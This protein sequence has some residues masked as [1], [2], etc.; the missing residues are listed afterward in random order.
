MYLTLLSLLLK[1]DETGLNSVRDLP[2][3]KHLP[4]V[5]LA[6]P[7]T[8]TLQTVVLHQLTFLFFFL[9]VYL[10]V[11]YPQHTHSHTMFTLKDIFYDK[12]LMVTFDR[13]FLTVC[14]V[15][16]IYLSISEVFI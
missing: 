3:F 13:F 2:L 5:S 11:M 12:T 1:I 7:L 14:T 4:P 15:C 10:A 9:K 6:C 16:F 8:T